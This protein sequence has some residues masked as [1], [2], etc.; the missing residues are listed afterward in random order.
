VLP[1]IRDSQCGFKAFERQIGMELIGQT[2]S[3]GWAFDVEFLALAGRAGREVVE[4]PVTW[5]YGH[6]STVRM[7]RD[8][9][10]VVGELWSIRRRVGRVRRSGPS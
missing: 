4:V 7:L 3:T 2:R 8:A 9:P 10:D 5:E 6:G 1:T